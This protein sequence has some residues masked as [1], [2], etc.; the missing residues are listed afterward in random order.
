MQVHQHMK[1]LTAFS[2]I[3]PFFAEEL[4]EM[5]YGFFRRSGTRLIFIRLL[6]SDDPI[7]FLADRIRSAFNRFISFR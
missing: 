4:H 1:D 2:L 7:P 3:V 6:A 5:F